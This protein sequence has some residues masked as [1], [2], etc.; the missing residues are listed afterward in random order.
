MHVRDPRA[1]T[2]QVPRYVRTAGQS[3]RKYHEASRVGVAWY[4]HMYVYTVF[5][6]IV[7]AQSINFTVCVMR[8]QFEGALYSRVR[9]NSLRAVY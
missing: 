3:S 4:V 7:C 9:S 2:V 1:H 8:G 6:Q 5:P